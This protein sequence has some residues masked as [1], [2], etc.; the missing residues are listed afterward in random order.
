MP[1]FNPASRLVPS[2]AAV[3]ICAS[4]A[5]QEHRH[6]R[7][8]FVSATVLEQSQ[9][10]CIAATERA[11]IEQQVRA[12]IL[13]ALGSRFPHLEFSDQNSADCCELQF[14]L[15]PE[16]PFPERA[17]DVV[18]AATCWHAR[19]RIPGRDNQL[20]TALTLRPGDA[21]WDRRPDGNGLVAET[22]VFFGTYGATTQPEQDRLVNG[23]HEQLMR[24]I[25]AELPVELSTDIAH[26][27]KTRMVVARTPRREFG[28]SLP[29]GS[30]FALA[31]KIPEPGFAPQP[32]QFLARLL[33]TTELAGATLD[34]TARASLVVL[35]EQVAGDAT[36]A[37]HLARLDV[38]GP[39]DVSVER[40][41]YIRR[42]G[43]VAARCLETDPD[44][45]HL[46]D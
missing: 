15:G 25:F 24:T 41:V 3:A 8:I 16:G 18:G 34:D 7:K 44:E 31:M 19:L 38:N 40:T 17:G 29:D 10:R 33:S 45:L 46:K 23:R 39:P 6:L 35:V 12:R 36:T 30:L 26:M 20:T 11:A 32:R 5:A 37:A 27:A 21:F 13:R 1:R 14:A 28:C 42:L 43:P 9:L 2:I 4:V 22:G